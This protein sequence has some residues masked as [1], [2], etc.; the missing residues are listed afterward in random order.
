[1]KGVLLSEIAGLYLKSGGYRL[2]VRRDGSA[3]NIK[4]YCATITFIKNFY[5]R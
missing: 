3:E 2:L 1:M 5:G 4:S